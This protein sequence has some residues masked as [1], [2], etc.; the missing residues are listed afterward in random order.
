MG[1]KEPRRYDSPLPCLTGL[2]GSQQDRRLFMPFKH[3]QT[4]V[5]LCN[6]SQPQLS[7]CFQS[8]RF[9]LEVPWQNALSTHCSMTTLRG[10]SQSPR[11]Q[12]PK[13]VK[14]CWAINRPRGIVVPSL[15]YNICKY[16]KESTGL[17]PHRITF[18]MCCGY[19]RQTLHLCLSWWFKFLGIFSG[20]HSTESW[21]KELYPEWQIIIR[22]I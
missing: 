5:A 12:T 4:H 3:N 14:Q 18:T 20:I 2:C 22:L 8:L 10:E 13:S 15:S 6:L 17:F 11:C 7:R 1:H 16:S 21:E 9:C 19:E